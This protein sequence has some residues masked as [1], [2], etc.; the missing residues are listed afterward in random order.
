MEPPSPAS[1][2]SFIDII[3]TVSSELLPIVK[4]GHDVICF[5]LHTYIGLI[6]LK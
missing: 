4:V 6:G 2:N 3:I 1:V 5:L